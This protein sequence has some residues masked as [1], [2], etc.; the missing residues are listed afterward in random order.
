MAKMISRGRV[1]SVFV[2]AVRVF[3]IVDDA[4]GVFV[5]AAGRVDCADALLA[6]SILLDTPSILYAQT[7]LPAMTCADVRFR[8]SQ[9]WKTEFSC[10][11]AD[12]GDA[13]LGVGNVRECQRQ[14]RPQDV[15]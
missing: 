12:G 7:F 5:T 14:T 10:P 4:D 1:G 13:G 11:H 2:E 8:A 3:D 15:A 6:D 9:S